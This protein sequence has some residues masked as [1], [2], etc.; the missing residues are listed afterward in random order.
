MM[1]AKFKAWDIVIVK[2]F[3]R[4]YEWWDDAR[5]EYEGKRLEILWARIAWDYRTRCLDPRVFSSDYT[6]RP[7]GSLELAQDFN[8]LSDIII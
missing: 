6:I 7:E 4:D 2:E 1:V 3:D 5:K 8:L